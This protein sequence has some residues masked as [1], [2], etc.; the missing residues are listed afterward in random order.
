MASV[1]V[2]PRFTEPVRMERRE[3]KGDYKTHNCSNVVTTLDHPRDPGGNVAEWGFEYGRLGFES[4][5]RATEW[6]CPW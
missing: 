6:I 4:P 3:T 5:T 1:E 2:G